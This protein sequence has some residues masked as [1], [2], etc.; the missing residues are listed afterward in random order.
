MP[1]IQNNE[2]AES[3]SIASPGTSNEVCRLPTKMPPFW[4]E[5]PIIWFAQVEVIAGQIAPTP[6]LLADL[7][8]RVHEIAPPSLQVVS[9]STVSAHASTTLENLTSG[10]AEIRRQ[11]RQLTTHSYRQLRPKSRGHPQ[12]RSRSKSHI[13]SDSS[14]RKYPT[15]QSLMVTDGCPNAPGRLFVTDC[16][17][18]MQFLVDTGSEI[19]VFPRSAVQQQRAKTT[20]QLSAANGTTINTYGY[21]NLEFDLSLR[22]DYPWRFVVADVT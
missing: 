17:T 8:E 19:C 20:Y 11:M 6:E 16:S 18:K 14:Y 22:R 21:I 13:R 5:K 1:R 3:D 2:D 15:W 9:T 4:S 10:I 12:G 7:A